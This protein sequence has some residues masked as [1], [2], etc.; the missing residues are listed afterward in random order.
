MLTDDEVLDLLNIPK[1]ID[2]KTPAVGFREVNGYRRCELELSTTEGGPTFSVFVRQNL[3]FTENYSIGLRYFTGDTRLG[4]ITLVRY[5]GPHGEYSLHTD[6]HFNATHIHRITAEEL[7]SGSS[8]P[9]EKHREI[10]DRY[11]TFDQALFAFFTDTK[12]VDY[13]QRFPNLSQMRLFDGHC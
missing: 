10:T 7:A 12:V 5:N 3:E 1:S 2:A 11:G 6:G 4:S 9:Q 13:E 8:Q